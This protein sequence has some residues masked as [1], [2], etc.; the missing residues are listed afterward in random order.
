MAGLGIIPLL[1]IIL[2]ILVLAHVLLWGTVV[3]L[4][5][6]LFGLLMGFGGGY[7]G[8]GRWY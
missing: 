6:L 7:Y 2:G 5:L 8:R 3:G 1:L 4:L